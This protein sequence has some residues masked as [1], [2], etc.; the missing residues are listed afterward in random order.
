MT[1]YGL[2]FPPLLLTI[3]LTLV[4]A[5]CTDTATKNFPAVSLYLPFLN[6]PDLIIRTR[7]DSFKKNLSFGPVGF[8][9]EL[10]VKKSV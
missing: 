7:Q 6:Y 10:T 8:K 9:K 2:L 5:F 3:T 1:V 4:P